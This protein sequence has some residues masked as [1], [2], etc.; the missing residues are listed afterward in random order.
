MILKNIMEKLKTVLSLVLA[1]LQVTL[2]YFMLLWKMVQSFI[3]YQLAHLFKRDL[4]SIEC[5]EED[6]MSLQLWNCFSYYPAVHRWDILDGQA[7]KVH[8]KR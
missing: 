7:G 1:L 5:L 3:A 2:Y 4:T 6:L 8:R